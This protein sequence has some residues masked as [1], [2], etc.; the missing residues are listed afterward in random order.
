MSSDNGRN[1]M[2]WD[3]KT[4]GCFNLKKRPKIEDFASSLPG[5]I[6]FSDIDAAVEVCGNLLF[7][8]WKAHQALG[9]GQSVLFKWIT[10]LCPATVLIVQGDAEKMV[11]NSVRAVQAGIIGDAVSSNLAD[12]RA[13]IR[14][15]SNWAMKNSAVLQAQENPSRIAWARPTLPGHAVR[16]PNG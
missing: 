12:L 1:P 6:A 16:T 3:C 5:R 15:W 8:E 9:R 11:V 14:V 4:Q 2:L 13:L 10:T 7:L